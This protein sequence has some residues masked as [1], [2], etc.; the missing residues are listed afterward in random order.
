MSGERL[1]LSHHSSCGGVTTSWFHEWFTHLTILTSI[2][3]SVRPA[4]DRMVV[5]VDVTIGVMCVLR[6][7]RL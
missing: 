6:L 4:F 7:L 1:I 3:R 2:C 5:N